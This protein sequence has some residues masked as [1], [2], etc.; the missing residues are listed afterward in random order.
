MISKDL[1]Y[2]GESQAQIKFSLISHTWDLSWSR[3]RL[4]DCSMDLS[5]SDF[6]SCR[7][8][9]RRSKCSLAWRSASCPFSFKMNTPPHI[10]SVY[11]IKDIHVCSNTSSHINRKV[12]FSSKSVQ[13]IMQII[14][15]RTVKV[16]FHCYSIHTEYGFKWKLRSIPKDFHTRNRIK[17]C[18]WTHSLFRSNIKVQKKEQALIRNT[19]V[20]KDSQIFC[21]LVCAADC[22]VSNLPVSYTE[23]ATLWC[24]SHWF[25]ERRTNF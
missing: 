6:L 9:N 11:L 20:W 23:R 24:H 1:L 3:R 18:I 10:Q 5:I 8:S 13:Y 21:F 14:A 2:L 19:D 25:R 22:L 15:G 17:R 7:V 12:S 4:R 16:F